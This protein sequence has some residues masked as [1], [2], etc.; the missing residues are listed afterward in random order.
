M[1]YTPGIP[2]AADIPSQ[3]QPLILTNFI[4]ANTLFGTDHFPFDFAT[5]A[6]RGLH[7]STRFQFLAAAPATAATQVA[8]YS[9]DVGLGVVELFFRRQTNGTEVQMTSNVVPVS[10]QNGQ[11]F[12]PGHIKLQWGL[13]PAVAGGQVPHVITFLTD[14]SA[15]A[16]VVFLAETRAHGPSTTANEPYVL[17]GTITAHQFTME[18]TA[19]T[20]HDI[21]WLAIGPA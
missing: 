14:F 12:L 2:Q 15:P 6:L 13:E 8:L 1:T 5:V 20:P 19:T 3:S 21:Q 11:T 10:L 7:Q 18:S 9:K 17:P 4:Q 16:F